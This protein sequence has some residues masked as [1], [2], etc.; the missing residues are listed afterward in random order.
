M[1]EIQLEKNGRKQK[2]EGCEVFREPLGGV[3]IFLRSVEKSGMFLAFNR[4][5]SRLFKVRGKKMQG[6]AKIPKMY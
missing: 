5:N 6:L 2:G 1:G 3:P 4:V